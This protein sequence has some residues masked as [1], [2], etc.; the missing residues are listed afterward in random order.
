MKIDEIIKSVAGLDRKKRLFL[1]VLVIFFLI[2]IGAGVSA[3]YFYQKWG[4]LRID[5]QKLA[6][7]E[8]QEIIKQVGRLIVLPEDETPTVATV[9]DPERLRDQP[10]FAK[11]KA[12]DK[13][14]IYTKAKKAILYDP[15]QNKIVEVAPLNI[16][17]IPQ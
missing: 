17:G 15:T 1:I 3:Y 6:E 16:G 9:T 2:A 5:P 12:G 8:A 13:V 11:A 10:F 4:E 7:S 14:L